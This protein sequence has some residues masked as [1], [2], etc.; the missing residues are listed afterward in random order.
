MDKTQERVII[1]QIMRSVR[2]SLRG[3]T[4]MEL[5][6]VLALICVLAALLLPALSS[7]RTLALSTRCQS[8]LRQLYTGLLAYSADHDMEFP[9]AYDTATTLSWMKQIAKINS[10]SGNY[11]T[12]TQ[13]CY[14][15]IFGPQWEKVSGGYGMTSLVVWQPS[16]HRTDDEAR[17]FRFRLK[18]PDG[19]PLLMDADAI[20]VYG[21]DN[22]IAAQPT[23]ARYAARHNGWANVLMADGHMEKVRYGETRWK[24][25]A[26]NDGSYY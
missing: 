19:W 13:V 16:V 1:N 15:P 6:V 26:L 5:V 18:R 10:V 17:F 3:F 7:A 4:L 11:L 22:P 2:F 20:A 9:K 8:N 14:C 24:Q 23:N 25:S 21:L 12:S